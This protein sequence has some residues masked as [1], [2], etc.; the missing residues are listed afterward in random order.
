MFLVNFIAETIQLFKKLLA[1]PRDGE[2][3]SLFTF[4]VFDTLTVTFMVNVIVET[5]EAID[6]FQLDPRSRP[7][8]EVVFNNQHLL[9]SVI[10][11]SLFLRILHLVITFSVL[12][13]IKS[14]SEIFIK[15]LNSFS[16]VLSDQ[17]VDACY[18]QLA[19]IHATIYDFIWNSWMLVLEQL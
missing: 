1:G 10:S 6:Q 19:Y 18:L 12:N 15:N 9:I 7:N 17:T 8:F 3:L 13:S 5:T 14:K 2:I 4:I 11:L 16:R